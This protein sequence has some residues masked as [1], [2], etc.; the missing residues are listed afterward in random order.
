MPCEAVLHSKCTNGH[1]QSWKCHE[2]LPPSC[3]TCDREAKAAA[4]KLNKEFKLQQKRDIEQQAH[5]KKMAELEA[6]IAAERQKIRDDRLAKERQ[7]AI[8]QKERDLEDAK[9]SSACATVANVEPREVPH[10][11][12]KTASTSS[13]SNQAVKSTTAKYNITATATPLPDDKTPSQLEWERQK[14]VEGARN[15]AIDAIMDMIGLESVKEQ[16]LRIKSKIA[17]TKRQ[18]TSLKGERFNIVLLGNPGTGTAYLNI[19]IS[20]SNIIS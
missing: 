15:D 17:V 13:T 5:D 14:N 7:D 3:K 2:N 11:A 10:R 18:N 1:P 12:S 20:L 6:K 9:A 16:V 4:D 8:R 19:I